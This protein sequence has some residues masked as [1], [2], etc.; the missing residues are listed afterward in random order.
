MPYYLGD[1]KFL[2]RGG[3]QGLSLARC[4]A[5]LD[6]LDATAQRWRKREREREREPTLE[7]HP[8]NIWKSPIVDPEA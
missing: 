5:L 8:C 1:L 4:P 2:F 6:P 7:K 3:P